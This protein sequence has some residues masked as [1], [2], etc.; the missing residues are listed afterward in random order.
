MDDDRK[1][2]TTLGV[3]ICSFMVDNGIC[4]RNDVDFI[5]MGN[6]SLC[7]YDKAKGGAG[8]SRQLDSRIPD[9]LNY[10][11]EKL[12]NCE[13]LFQLLDPYSQRYADQI[14]IKA[15]KEWLEEE[16]KHRE[17][18]PTEILEAYPKAQNASFKDI[19]DKIKE[20]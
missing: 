13:S 16:S 12:A 15:T 7:I 14:D 10:C 17:D 5:R 4:E 19:A 6:G 3:L 1:I 20:D 9:A 11:K 18:V 8:Y 2:L